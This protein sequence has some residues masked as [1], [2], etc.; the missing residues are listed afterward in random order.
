MSDTG[1]QI[2]LLLLL[3]LLILIPPR[4]FRA[5]PGAA[6]ILPAAALP[7]PASQQYRPPT[8]RPKPSPPPNLTT[9]GADRHG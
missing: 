7:R 4:L 8:L 6:G 1:C 5:T 2:L 3:L 9:D